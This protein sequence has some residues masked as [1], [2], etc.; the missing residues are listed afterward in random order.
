MWGGGG[1]NLT[2][3]SALFLII[4]IILLFSTTCNLPLGMGNSIDFE[5]PVL[6]LDPLPNP[7]HVNAGVSF[8]VIAKDNIGIE[9]IVCRDS[10]NP[11]R[12]LGETKKIGTRV[13]Y[14]EKKKENIVWDEFEI[15]VHFTENDNNTKIPG[16][17]IAWDKIGNSGEESIAFISFIVDIRPP[18]F[19]EPVVQRSPARSASLLSVEEL[20]DLENSDPFADKLQYVDLYQNGVFWIDANV[21]EDET[22]AQTVM[23]YLYDM[24]NDEEG[25]EVYKANFD[26]NN[27][28]AP[29]WTIRE[30][31]IAQGGDLKGLN[32]SSRLANGGR[33]Y[34]RVTLAASDRAQNEGTYDEKFED[35]LG[36]I[37]VYKDAD[38]PKE[39]LAGGIGEFIPPGTT[40]PID[41]FDDD[42]VEIVYADLLRKQQ[43]DNYGYGLGSGFTEK[44]VLDKLL[45][46]FI[47]GEDVL[48]W[49]NEKITNKIKTANIESTTVTVST[50]ATTAACGEYKLVIFVKDKKTLPHNNPKDTTT[51]ADG[52]WTSNCYDFTVIDRNASLI[53]ID[54]RN[55]AEANYIK[56]EKPGAV[57]GDSPEES[58]TP[59]GDGFRLTNGRYF[60]LNGYTL[61]ENT[62]SMPGK[63]EVFRLAWI[64]FALM[65]DNPNDRIDEVKNALSANKNYPLGVQYW[66]LSNIGYNAERY[67]YTT[68][69]TDDEIAGKN[70][71]KQVFRKRFD[72]LG[73]SDDV[74]SSWRNFHYGCNV[75]HSNDCREN[76]DKYF[77]LYAKNTND[78]ETFKTYRLLGNKNPPA[79]KVYDLT[80]VPELSAITGIE[81]PQVS[82]DAIRNWVFI[83]T[84]EF[85]NM[86]KIEGYLSNPFNTYPEESVYK[87][88]VMPEALHGV[89]VDLATFAMTDVTATGLKSAPYVNADNRDMVFVKKHGA[90]VNSLNVFE[91]KVTNM[92]DL[93]VNINRTIAF[94][95]TAKLSMIITPTASGTYGMND[96]SGEPRTITLKAQFTSSVMVRSNSGARP[97]LNIRY[98]TGLNH[99][100]YTSLRWSD[101][102]E[103][104]TPYGYLDF[105]FSIPEGA[106]GRLETVDEHN[107]YLA[108]PPAGETHTIASQQS[109]YQAY[110]DRPINLIHESGQSARTSIIDSEREHNVF[111]PGNGT[112][113]GLTWDND[114]GNLQGG[115]SAVNIPERTGKNIILDGKLPILL[116]VRMTKT[117]EAIGGH[118]WY[119][120]N[121]NEDIN[122]EFSANKPIRINRSPV[123]IFHIRRI[124]AQGANKGNPTGLGGELVEDDFIARY[125]R[126]VTMGA[127]GGLLFAMKAK[128]INVGAAG[129]YNHGVI[130]RVELNYDNGT[131]V[132][133]NN[134]ELNKDLLSALI[135]TRA[136]TIAVDNEVPNASQPLL[137]RLS[138][139]EAPHAPREHYNYTPILTM[140]NTATNEQEPWGFNTEYSLNGGLDWDNYN[141]PQRTDWVTT[142]SG[143]ITIRPGTWTLVTRQR[144]KS[145]NESDPSDEYPI[146]IENNFPKMLSIYTK[147][148]KGV[149][150][151]GDTLDFVIDFERPVV[152]T[153]SQDAYIIVSDWNENKS[154]NPSSLKQIR[155]NITPQPR[156]TAVIGANNIYTS[157]NAGN[158]ENVNHTLGANNSVIRGV[159]VG[160]NHYALR[161]V[162]AN[163][164][165]LHNDNEA[166]PAAGNAL[167]LGASVTITTANNKT[168]LTFTW[169]ITARS[170][171]MDSGITI[172]GINLNGVEDLYGNTMP[173]L[174][175]T[176]TWYP[177]NIGHANMRPAG[178][179]VQ[180]LNGQLT[181]ILTFPPTL[182]ESGCIPRSGSV[183]NDSSIVLSGDRKT[184]TLKFSH[185]IIKEMGNI[186]IRPFGI[187]GSFPVPPVFPVEGYIDE[188]GTYIPGF[189]EVINSSNIT[190]YAAKNN[191][192]VNILRSYLRATTFTDSQ[193]RML[194]S[195]GNNYVVVNANG[196]N[197][198]TVVSSTYSATAAYRTTDAD[199]KMR[200]TGL[201]MGPYRLNTQGL[202]TGEGYDPD[203]ARA[204]A[205]N[206]LA[207]I[208]FP[209]DTSTYNGKAVTTAAADTNWN[210]VSGRMVPDTTPKYVLAFEL[211]INDAP[212]VS[213]TATY[214]QTAVANIRTALRAARYRWRE[215]NVHDSSVNQVDDTTIVINLP[216]A[217][218]KGFMWEINFDEGS[219][220]D[221][222]GNRVEEVPVNQAHWFWTAGVQTPVIRVD[223]KSMDYRNGLD[224]QTNTS[225]GTPTGFA[226]VNA[227]RDS[228]NTVAFKVESET[229]NAV[230]SYGTLLGKSQRTADTAAFTYG[231]I[232]TALSGSVAGT[233]G[234][235]PLVAINWTTFGTNPS[236]AGTDTNTMGTWI[237]PNLL[238]RSIYGKS[239]GISNDNLV[240]LPGLRYNVTRNGLTTTIQGSGSYWGFRSFNRDAAMSDISGITLGSTGTSGSITI[241]GGT[242]AYLRASKNY[243]AATAS[244]TQGGVE[245]VSLRGYEG[246]FKTVIV[247]RAAQNSDN[248][249]FAVRNGCNPFMIFGSNTM[250]DASIQGF[251]MQLLTN[252]YRYLKFP[253]QGSNDQLFWMS[254]EIVSGWYSSFCG[255]Q[256]Q[257]GMNARPFSAAGDAGSLISGS[258]GDLTYSYSQDKWGTTN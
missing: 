152:T 257:G 115:T 248:K 256:N 41:V 74:N 35:F 196:G 144:D 146:D 199:G 167:N 57:T 97:R 219:F 62:D 71:K 110:F 40:I 235:A 6:R 183:M 111:L 236:N 11:D 27:P 102:Q 23:L 148:P 100:T 133:L 59:G 140:T 245:A 124:A 29:R 216:T 105:L 54:T 164:F 215:F 195:S 65:K 52:I 2:K 42:T 120:Y 58:T 128:D 163:T 205:Y 56:D 228:F 154:D 150:K 121:T 38:K 18:M 19:E 169:N 116:D 83:E 250:S 200:T 118:N 175:T 7:W 126:P 34:L 89:E 69:G 149:Y 46:M 9:E 237:Y 135:G 255:S 194:A 16:E 225:H 93:S 156:F 246:I 48:N 226:D 232:E 20:R 241:S 143:V 213:G 96:Q 55:P 176:T 239:T 61:T 127:H 209:A 13:V 36:Y 151:S 12:I 30:N 119:Y 171:T 238:R 192:S 45:G 197:S 90:G 178:H 15:T 73:G 208:T 189:N 99:W 10:L 117:P 157:R 161:I 201:D 85:S 223:R 153:L 32:Y 112:G 177:G 60:T 181:E 214:Q 82:Y 101:T 258:Y 191:Y 104:N 234:A 162:S 168:S 212:P 4:P 160:A 3:P 63:V 50:G 1:V 68:D 231:A 254:T 222:A 80:R 75:S 109:A 103:Y 224:L 249:I 147:Q 211:G 21:I 221:R 184:I 5:P 43:F 185:R 173:A 240:K 243:V 136:F 113:Y 122:V 138:P 206:A 53:V 141:A 39:S 182:V 14:D 139:A 207:E 26:N 28:F 134:N 87:A 142:N 123:V 81:A 125:E 24:E 25:K 78:N 217:L 77:I 252:D 227:H 64:P 129:E 107:R 8:K 86:E 247:L 198:A 17:V 180:N 229:P 155:L 72:I 251:P 204:A 203:N 84:N 253:H 190:D 91:F 130:D 170:K 165:T 37:C 166:A 187:N 31:D 108:S 186:Y 47:S 145:G 94:T 137:S 159:H 179:T 174:V 22:Y 70:H 172:T 158:S 98:E 44:D 218:A 220:V 67:S 114:Y 233:G 230:I 106:D 132:D 131:I 244:V 88:Y 79:L 188:D 95:N 66:D 76:E 92:L 210:P 49:D 33:I 242:E 51:A 202:V 193:Y